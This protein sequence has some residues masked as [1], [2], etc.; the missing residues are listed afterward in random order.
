MDDPV[1]ER[2][3][4]TQ[5]SDVAEETEDQANQPG[6]SPARSLM[7]RDIW[8]L[9]RGEDQRG[10]EGAVDARVAASVPQAGLADDGRAGRGDRG[11]AGASVP[12]RSGD[13]RRDHRQDDDERADGDRR[14]VPG[15]GACSSGRRATR[16]RIWWAGW[17]AGASGPA[18]AD[19]PAP[20]VDVD[21]LL[22]AA[23]GGGADLAADER[24]AGARLARHRRRR[25]AV[26]V[27]ADAGRRGRDPAAARRAAGAGRLPHLP[28][29]LRRERDLPDRRRRARTGRRGRRSRTSPRTCRRRSRGC[30]SCGRSARSGG[31]SSG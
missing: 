11:G 19:L 18:D 29:A 27:D 16:R 4:E 12:R 13:R 9:I 23:Q 10:A 25:D 7:F 20:A 5:G 2:D 8:R 3:P 31:T 22:H 14:R 30:G 21:R 17:A 28:A 24:R 1:T 15:L 26:P 6:G